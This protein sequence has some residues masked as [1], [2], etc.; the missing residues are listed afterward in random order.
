MIDADLDQVASK[1]TRDPITAERPLLARQTFPG[2]P[3]QVRAARWWLGACIAGF[4]AADDA[5]L[6]CSELVANAIIHSDSG[7]PDGIFT[8]RIAVNHDF[9]RIEVLD[10]G[11]RWT[12]ARTAL[13]EAGQHADD[14]SQCGRGLQIVAAI[15]SAWGVTG[16]QEGRTVWCEIKSG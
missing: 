3:G 11:G 5:T 13:E 4:S 7:L 12:G 15:A 14:A 6:A 9:I 10:Q 16:D 8:V 1:P 2:E